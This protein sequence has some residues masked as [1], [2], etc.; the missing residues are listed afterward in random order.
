MPLVQVIYVQ[1][2]QAEAYVNSV[3]L[4]RKFHFAMDSLKTMQEEME[5]FSEFTGIRIYLRSPIKM[6]I[7]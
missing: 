6:V 1:R 7:L 2:L 4:E 5:L 3:L